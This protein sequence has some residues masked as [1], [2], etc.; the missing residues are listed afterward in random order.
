[1]YSTILI[2]NT[3]RKFIKIT[4]SKDKINKIFNNFPYTDDIIV[5]MHVYASSIN[6][7]KFSETQKTELLVFFKLGKKMQRDHFGFNIKMP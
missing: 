1:M 3:T 4:V 2:Q 6:Q 7:L 5:I